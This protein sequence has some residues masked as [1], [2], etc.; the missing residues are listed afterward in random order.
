[1]SFETKTSPDLLAKL[2]SIRG[3]DIYQEYGKQIET[4]NEI[5]WTKMRN[6]FEAGARLA[7]LNA[8][9]PQDYK[10]PDF[11]EWKT[12]YYADDIQQKEKTKNEQ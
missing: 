4:A 6:A 7:V 12:K 11:E 10:Y 3:L 1:M 5:H 9:W 8:K 2:L